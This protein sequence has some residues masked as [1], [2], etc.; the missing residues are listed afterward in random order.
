MLRGI[1]EFY[2]AMVHHYSMIWQHIFI[3]RREREKNQIA[4]HERENLH[5]PHTT[6][7]LIL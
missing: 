3:E 5:I 7:L 6:Y 4:T 1:L 2:M